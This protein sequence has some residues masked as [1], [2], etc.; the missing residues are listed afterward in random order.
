MM[1]QLKWRQQTAFDQIMASTNDV[2][3]NPCK[4]F[5]DDAGGTEKTFICKNLTN[6]LKGQGKTILL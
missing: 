1:A 3:S 2:S 4:Y 6:V 5:L